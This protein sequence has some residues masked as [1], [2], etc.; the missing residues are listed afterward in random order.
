MTLEQY[1]TILGKRWKLILA[2]FIIVAL[3]AYIGTKLLTPLYQSTALVQVTIRSQSNQADYSSLL[4]SDELVQTEAQ[5]ATSNSVL[6]DVASRYPGM[7]AEQLAKEVTATSR[8]NTQLFEIVVLDASPTR[9]AALANDIA[10][11]LINQQRQVTQLENSREQQQL[12]Q[13]LDATQR[14]IDATTNQI[15][16]L[17]AKEGKQAQIGVLQTQ[18]SGLQQH[19]N[20]WQTTLA[21][22]ELTQAQNA[23]FL[24]VAQVAEPN[25]KPAQPNVL[26]NTSGGLLAGLLLGMLVAV[27]YEQLDTRVRTAETLTQLFGWTVL[28]TVWRARSKEEV[29]NPTGRGAYSESYRILRTNIGFS[30]IDEPLRSLMV[31]SA[32]PR[33]GKSVIAANLAIFM[34]R[35]GKTTLLVDAD[36]RRP[37]QYDVFNL[38]PDKMGLSNAVLALSMPKRSETP[39]LGSD[40]AGSYGAFAKP[41]APNTHAGQ[42]LHPATGGSFT[43]SDVS[44][45]PFV[46]SVGIPNLWVMPSGPLPPSPS[47]L[48]DSKAMQRLFTEI[49]N[50]GIEVVIFDTPPALG[51]SDVSILASKVDGAL[52]VVDIT[53]ARKRNLKQTKAILEQASARV[54]GCVVNK[55]ARGRHE[56]S[57]AYYYYRGDEQDGGKNHNAGGKDI[58]NTPT[59]P[60]NALSR[61]EV[62]NGS[63]NRVKQ[64]VIPPG[65]WSS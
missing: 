48:L 11:T 37:R 64:D 57:Y 38:S 19:Y 13:D 30:G 14:Q 20:Q 46:H 12:Q 35:A 61:P 26:L 54:L 55:Q 18:L 27:L 63:G 39:P 60:V 8:L 3:G 9:A 59:V 41:P 25:P 36:L 4:A 32:I 2:C 23:D 33:D 34:A 21:Q 43:G 51:L 22:L 42:R 31:T 49:T 47:E 40:M 10:A 58:P 5:L 24:R 6:R 7:T 52:V 44:L 28:A 15:A 65:S 50:A 1:W 16:A 62:Q 53:R 56:T 45:E 17:Q 29:V